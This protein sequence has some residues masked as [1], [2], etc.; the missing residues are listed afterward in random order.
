[1]ASTSFCAGCAPRVADLA[2]QGSFARLGILKVHWECWS[3]CN[4]PCAFCYRTQGA[5]LGTEP[6][7]QLLEAVSTSGASTIVF[8]G[9]DPSIR[10]DIVS[11]ITHA[12]LLG[13]RVEVQTNAHYVTQD[14]LTALG[15]VNL[16]GLSLDGPDAKTH[17]RFRGKPGNFV[18]VVRLLRLLTES[19]VPVVVRSIV[20][21][22]NFKAVPRIARLLEGMPT[23][24]RW[25]L[26]EFSALGEGFVQREKYALGRAVFDNVTEEIRRVFAGP[27]HLDI[28]RAE[29]KIGTYALIT[30]S[31]ALY[32]TTES[33]VEGIFPTL[34]SI[35]QEH[36]RVLAERLPFSRENHS[37]RYTDT[38]ITG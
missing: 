30:P 38:F 5:P 28:Y 26:L 10:P 32:G 36:L 3:A 20:A 7:M 18:R 33:T 8:A 13:L 37:R 21:K 23:V 31:G 4:L 15:T 29:A 35:C 19:N 34:G 27:A 14:F 17:D 6:S 1:M 11:L 24:V 12:R 25:S 2:C 22:S 9:G 16:V